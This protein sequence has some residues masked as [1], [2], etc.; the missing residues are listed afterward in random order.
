MD[1]TRLFFVVDSKKDNREIFETYEDASDF[2]NTIEY[3]SHPR[4]FIAKVKN[5]FKEDGEWN[6][7][8][9]ADTFTEVTNI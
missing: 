8:D 3:N 1:K 6:Y 2:Y 5:A 4:M 7:E 9:K